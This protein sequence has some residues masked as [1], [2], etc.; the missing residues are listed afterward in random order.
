MHGH[1]P[2]FIKGETEAQSAALLTLA[3]IRTR[4]VWLWS[5]GF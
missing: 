1:H 4:E 5:P 3:G 2:H